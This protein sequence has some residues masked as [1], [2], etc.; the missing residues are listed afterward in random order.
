M[1]DDERHENIDVYVEH[2]LDLLEYKNREIA[3][4]KEKNPP[5][6]LR[7]AYTQIQR[8]LHETQEELK[9]A[10]SAL[11]SYRRQSL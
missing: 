10:K 4:M 11:E 5:P 7:E 8:L 6:G 2:L 1:C 9:I 3:E